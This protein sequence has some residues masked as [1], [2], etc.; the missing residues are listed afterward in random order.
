VAEASDAYLTTNLS[1]IKVRITYFP[2]LNVI[3]GIGFAVTFLVGGLWVLGR[4]VFGLT[5][6]LT[7]GA[8]VTFVIYAQQFLWPIIRLGDVVDDYERAKAAG[9]RVQGVLSREPAVRDRPDAAPLAVDEGAVTYDDVQFGY[10]GGTVLT[11]V[12]FT[13]EGGRPS[14]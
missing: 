4:P 9:S 3:S 8:F 13:V 6:A 10:A 12:D 7:P 2:G 1:A 5:G 14:G 11:D